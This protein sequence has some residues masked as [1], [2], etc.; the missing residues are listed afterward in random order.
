MW[1]FLMRIL[2]IMGFLKDLINGHE[3]FFEINKSEKRIEA[4][5]QETRLTLIE[6]SRE[7]ETKAA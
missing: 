3:A 5:V 4:K 6:D 7:E 1:Q 2:F